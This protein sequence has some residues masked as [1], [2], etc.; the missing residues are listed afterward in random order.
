MSSNEET[1][2]KNTVIAIPTAE[3]RLTMHFGHCREFALFDVDRKTSRILNDRRLAPPAH[4]PGVLP[5]WL[6]DQGATLIIAGG[7][8]RRA[9][10]LFAQHGI[11]VVVGAPAEPPETVVQRYLDDE[12]PRGNNLC[13]H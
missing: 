6:H 8:G 11:E 1:D 5:A 2:G 10:D 13:D 7:M 3:G 9:Q 4:E 12:L